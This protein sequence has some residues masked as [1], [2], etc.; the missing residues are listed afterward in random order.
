MNFGDGPD[1]KK[2]VR[3]GSTEKTLYADDLKVM[4]DSK[5]ETAEDIARIVVL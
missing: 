1:K 4:A 5:G 2:G 3:T